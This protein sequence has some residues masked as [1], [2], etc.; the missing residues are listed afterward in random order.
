MRLARLVETLPAINWL[1]TVG[2]LERQHPPWILRGKSADLIQL[3]EL[4]LGECEFDRR[5]IVLKLVEAFRAND[6]RGYHRLYQ[7]PCERETCRTT[8]M[9]FR[10]RSHHVE[11]LPGPLFVHDGKVEVS[12]ARIR[13]LLVRPAELAGKQ[14]TGKRTPH[15]QADLFGFQHGNDF[16]FEIA[17]GDRVISLKRV[18]SGQV[19]KLGDAEGFGDLPCLP[20]GA[21]D[22][23]NLS[24]LLQGVASATRPF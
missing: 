23:S 20:V 18:E 10:H 1:Q 8:S 21:A 12:A 22:V 15:E 7:E 2:S 24:L 16:P 17:A 11:D 6:D 5:E 3:P 14:A 4:V 19:P 13:G 9:C